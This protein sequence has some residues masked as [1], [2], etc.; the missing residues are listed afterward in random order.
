MIN[1]LPP[2]YQNQ[3]DFL[4][5]DPTKHSFIQNIPTNF[6]DFDEPDSSK[7]TFIKNK[8][9]GVFL[10]IYESFD[11]GTLFNIGY[12]SLGDNG[13]GDSLTINGYKSYYKKIPS[14]TPFW[15]DYDD[16]ERIKINAEIYKRT[17]VIILDENGNDES[18]ETS[19]EFVETKEYYV[20]VNFEERIDKNQKGYNA[21][22]TSDDGRLG[23]RMSV[24]FEKYSTSSYHTYN[25]FYIDFIRDATTG[26]T[27]VSQYNDY[28][29]T[30]EDGK[31]IIESYVTNCIINVLRPIKFVKLDPKYLPDEI[32]NNLLPEATSEDSGR[33]PI[34]NGLGTWVLGNSLELGCFV[35]HGTA[36]S[37]TSGTY[38]ESWLDITDAFTAGKT[39]TLIFSV[40][41]YSFSLR[42]HTRSGNVLTTEFFN[43]NG[44][45]NYIHINN[46]GT[47]TLDHFGE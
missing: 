43:N 16:V 20:D 21:N 13:S 33:I 8:P 34:V 47:F 12:Y 31:R 44:V 45:L 32:I 37:A 42:V 28:T 6:S 24:Y 38:Q 9:F 22:G 35:I 10:D 14:D 30:E 40:D 7:I 39:V 1:K 4:E 26:K 36:T 29:T 41:Q 23:L 18:S 11:I 25:T 15:F 19:Y 46:D 3:V 5:K 2:E 17:E 27:D